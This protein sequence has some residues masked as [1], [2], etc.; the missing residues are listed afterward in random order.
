MRIAHVHADLPPESSG[1][2]A[3]QVHRLAAAQVHA[4]RDVTVFSFSARPPGAPYPVSQLP[5]LPGRVQSG[6]AR[7]FLAGLAFARVDY[8]GFDLVHFHG[9]SYLAR[10]APPTVRTFYGSALAELRHATSLRFALSQLVVYPMELVAMLRADRVVGI[11]AATGWA[12]PR[13]RRTVPCG[14]DTRVFRPGDVRSPA[15]SILFV[16][17]L[18]GRKRGNLL[19]RAFSDVVRA[20][21]PDAE[22]WIVGAE[23]ISAPGVRCLGRLSEE[24]LAAAYRRAWV[25]CLP[26]SYEGFGVPYV[27]AM[28]SGTPVV[29]SPNPGAAEITAGGAHGV[30]VADAELGPELARLLTD[31]SAR[32]A[33]ARAGLARAADYDWANVV[34]QY[35]RIY[36]ELV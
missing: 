14:V 24:E 30:L 4:G 21:V 22:L 1:G 11:S 17:T 9:D 3:W 5:R 16:G 31:G 20:R 25:F 6:F 12:L 36:T 35:D 10:P 23:T 7:L 27:E 29:A 18:S 15:P 8:S 32:D 33:L 28:A 13:V 26:S 19:V 2:V 34:A